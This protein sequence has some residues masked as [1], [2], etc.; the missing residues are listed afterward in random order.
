MRV[1]A[2]SLARSSTASG[3][4]WEAP[5]IRRS[6]KTRSGVRVNRTSGD[7]EKD[8]SQTSPRGA[9]FAPLP[10]PLLGAAASADRVRDRPYAGTGFVCERL[11]AD[12]ASP[13][14]LPAPRPL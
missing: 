14:W 5:F 12:F 8:C 10:C 4:G 1:A 6:F 13:V 9:P 3:D 11:S 7:I 2:I